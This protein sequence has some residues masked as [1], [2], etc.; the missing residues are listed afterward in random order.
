MGQDDEVFE[1]YRKR[2]KRRRGPRKRVAWCL[3][4]DKGRILMVQRAYGS[5]KGRWS[6]PG[7]YVDPG[8][9]RRRAAYRETK[10]ETG[11][12]VEITHRLFT[13]RNRA[14]AVFVGRRI[15]GRLRY[16]RSEAL[17]ARWRDPDKIKSFELAFEGD[18]KALRLWR[19][20]KAVCATSE[21][22][23]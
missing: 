23:Y 4:E 12:V 14:S 16:Q 18:R 3:V 8:E 1:V 22:T 19:D 9:S 5:R 2:R 20:I 10:E 7:G 17:D 15:G 11:I 21:E 6:L 13:S